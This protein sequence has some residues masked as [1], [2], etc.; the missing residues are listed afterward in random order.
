MN[1]A[2]PI[3]PRR[4]ELEKSAAD[5]FDIWTRC[6]APFETGVDGS[7]YKTKYIDRLYIGTMLWASKQFPEFQ[8]QQK[9]V[10][11]PQC[12]KPDDSRGVIAVSRLFITV[13]DDP[14]TTFKA[15]ARFVCQNCCF[16]EY[17]PLTKDPREDGRN[18]AFERMMAMQQAQSG[19]SDYGLGSLQD[20]QKKYGS[21]LAGQSSLTGYGISPAMLPDEKESLYRLMQRKMGLKP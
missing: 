21:G 10:F 16:E 19:A 6:G 7:K 14:M 8:I 15:L 5:R 17:H 3:D 4:K 18:Q 2:S 1:A 9:A 13:G 12:Q 11:C 20:Y